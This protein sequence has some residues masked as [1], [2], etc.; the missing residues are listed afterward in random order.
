MVRLGYGTLCVLAAALVGCS[1]RPAPPLALQFE[2]GGTPDEVA[3]VV[4]AASDWNARVG[5]EL[6]YVA[7]HGQEPGC[8]RVLVRFVED[9]PPAYEGLIGLF[10]QVGCHYQVSILHASGRD[11][12]NATHELG[13]TL[14]LGHSDEPRSVMFW[15]TGP[16]TTI[17]DEDVMAVHLH[18]A[19]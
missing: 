5:R 11:R 7:E 14:D 15:S 4:A 9:M 3:T 8:D 17:Q 19:L 1:E 6:F 10:Q 18:W 16:R 2:P 13:H 12:A